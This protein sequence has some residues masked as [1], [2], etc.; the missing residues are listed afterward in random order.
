MA[1][2]LGACSAPGRSELPPSAA[3]TRTPVSTT[4][5]VVSDSPR[6][7][8]VLTVIE[9]NHGQTSALNGMPYLA[10]MARTYGRTTAYRTLTHPSLPNY[11]AMAGGSTFGVHDD[12]SPARHPLAGRSVFDAAVATRHTAK[13]YAEGL[14]SVCATSPRG[15]YAVKHNPWSY[16]SD[17]ASQKAC[18][19]GDV[20]SGT[21]TAGP[22]DNDVA[23]GTLPHVG[24][25][26]PD[27][28]H[29]AHDCS[30]PT[31]DTWLKGWLGTVMNGPDYRSGRL[32]VVVTFDE[33]DGPGK[34]SILTVVIAPT[35]HRRT[36]TAPL[37]HLSWCRWMT[38]LIDAPPLRQAAGAP[39]L[40]RAF[41]L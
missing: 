9:E 35:L 33:V 21:T 14:P 16:F 15:R 27:L 32:A 12:G 38:D 40:G 23:R 7:T 3:R 4:P 20:P 10:S 36:V 2:L 24:L 17:T 39:S 22:L 34:G 37:S 5:V 18:H 13:T 31:A 29:D 28:C 41:G 11:L 19:T 26:V 30:L 25:L 1:L 8:K 6:I